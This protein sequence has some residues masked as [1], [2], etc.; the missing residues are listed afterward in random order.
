MIC[1]DKEHEVDH[2]GHFF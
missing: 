1:K 2:E